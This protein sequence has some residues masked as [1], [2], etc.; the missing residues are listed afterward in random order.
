MEN[1]KENFMGVI[2]GS[3]VSQHNSTKNSVFVCWYF[4]FGLPAYFTTSQPKPL[5][6]ETSYIHGDPKL[7]HG[8]QVSV[9][10]P[11]LWRKFNFSLCL[12]R[13][14]LS[15]NIL[16]CNFLFARLPRI[17]A[18]STALVPRTSPGREVILAFSRANGSKLMRNESTEKN[19]SSPSLI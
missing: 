17:C 18:T 16:S 9:S 6:N 7:R 19:G 8:S 10:A 4:T 3:E 13:R 14:S 5:K 12:A 11:Y 15:H 2:L 1:S